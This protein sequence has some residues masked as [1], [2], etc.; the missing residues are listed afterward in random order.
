MK[1]FPV[2]C[3]T[4]QLFLVCA[5]ISIFLLT[6]K[7]IKRFAS[8][9]TTKIC[10]SFFVNGSDNCLIVIY[11]GNLLYVAGVPN[12]IRGIKEYFF[13]TWMAAKYAFYDLKSRMNALYLLF[14]NNC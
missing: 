5:S 14:A 2:F 7:F 11:T 12:Y 4:V 10:H 6:G 3:A 1:L 13:C 9:T 8:F